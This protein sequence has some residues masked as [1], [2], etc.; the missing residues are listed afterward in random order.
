M[1]SMR[2]TWPGASSMSCSISI[3]GE[4][5]RGIVVVNNLAS[6]G[7]RLGPDVF[8][9]A[10]KRVPLDLVGMSAEEAGGLGEIGNLD[11]A[12]FTARYR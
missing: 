11:L 7:R 8:A 2:P 10:A 12:A 5:E 1:K 9:S 3:A 4:L 6:R